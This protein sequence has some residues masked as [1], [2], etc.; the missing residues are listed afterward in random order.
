MAEK[1]IRQGSACHP[2]TATIT[3]HLKPLKLNNQR[4]EALVEQLYTINKKLM[5]LEGRLAGKEQNRVRLSN[6]AEY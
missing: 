5:G 1:K 6:C 3:R 4:I 2:V